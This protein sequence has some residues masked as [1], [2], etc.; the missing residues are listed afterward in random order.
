MYILKVLSST[1]WGGEP[2]IMSML[3]KAIVHSKMNYG[4][5]LFKSEAIIH[6]DKPDIIQNQTLRHYL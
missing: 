1:Q 4:A 2:I 6:M 5:F 3:Y